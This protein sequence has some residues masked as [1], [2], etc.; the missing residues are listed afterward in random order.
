MS[1]LA[2]QLQQGVSQFRVG[3]G[4]E[5][6]D[7]DSAKAAHLA[8]K[9]R[10]RAFLD[11]R[12]D[13]TEAQA[14]SHQQCAFGK[15]YYGDGSRLYGHLPQFSAIE[16]PHQALHQAIQEIVTLRRNGR[17]DEAESSYRRID[18]LSSEVVGALDALAVAASR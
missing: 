7:F 17:T 6:F 11:G 14:V 2:A 1:A 16:A 13:L 4:G 10:V 12:G 18:T 3:E 15:W 8:W 9:A 5:G